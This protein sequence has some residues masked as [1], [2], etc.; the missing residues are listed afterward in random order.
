MRDDQIGER[1]A[2]LIEALKQPAETIFEA[3]DKAEQRRLASGQRRAQPGETGRR[4]A[5]G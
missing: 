5:S 2:A 4:A 3:V 1:D